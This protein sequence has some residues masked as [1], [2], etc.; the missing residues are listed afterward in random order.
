[1]NRPLKAGI[2]AAIIVSIT[3]YIAENYDARVA[4]LVATAPIALTVTLFLKEKG[5][6]KEWAEGFVFGLLIYFV[7]ALML[8]GIHTN[9]A[10][11]TQSVFM[12]IGIWLFLASVYMIIMG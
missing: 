10:S 3:A 8:Y 6:F 1:M 12:G 11:K 7:S 5:E 9:G 2:F 4:G